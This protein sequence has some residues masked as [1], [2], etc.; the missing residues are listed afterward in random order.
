MD[1]LEAN[2]HG[3]L[4]VL[5]CLSHFGYTVLRACGRG[6]G[7]WPVEGLNVMAVRGFYPPPPRCRARFVPRAVVR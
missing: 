6:V 4:F 7:F 2:Q 5:T 1:V 3:G